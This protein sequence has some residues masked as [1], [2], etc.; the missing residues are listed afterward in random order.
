MH[1]L[2]ERPGSS[3]RSSSRS[4]PGGS[5][6]ASGAASWGDLAACQ[7]YVGQG[8]RPAAEYHERDFDWDEHAAAVRHLVDEQARRGAELRAAAAA[9]PAGAGP[10]A[11]N[12]SEGSSGGSGDDGEGGLAGSSTAEGSGVGPSARQERRERRRQR[13][14]QQ[15]LQ[16]AAAASA[17]AAAASTSGQGWASGEV[18]EPEPWEAFYRAHPSARFFKER[19]YLLLEF[20]RLLTCEHVA[21]IGCGCGSAILPVLKANPGARSTCTDISTTCL[22]QLLAAAAAEGIDRSRLSVFPADATDPAAAPSFQGVGADALLIMFTLSAVDPDRQLV[23]LTHA[24]A[25]LRP[26]GR[27][28]IRDH[29]LYDMVQLRR[30][31]EQ[32]LGPNLY[33]QSDGTMAYFFSL[34]ALSQRA[35]AA[36]LRVEECRYVT[37]VNRNRKTGQEL[38][39]VFVHG[40]FVKPG[41]RELA[42]PLLGRLRSQAAARGSALTLR[43]GPA[44]TRSNADPPAAFTKWLRDNGRSYAAGS[45]LGQ[46]VFARFLGLIEAG[47]RHNSDPDSLYAMGITSEL[48]RGLTGGPGAPTHRRRLLQASADSAPPPA[49]PGADGLGPANGT[50]SSA[51]GA[52]GQMPKTPRFLTSGAVAASDPRVCT[53]P[54]LDNR[55]TLPPAEQQGSCGSCWAFAIAAAMQAQGFQAETQRAVPRLSKQQ[56]VDCSTF[57]PTYGPD[58]TNQGC[59]YGFVPVA[60]EYI[61]QE[62]LL[63][64]QD[65]PYEDAGFDHNNPR[66]PVRRTC[67]AGLRAG[68]PRYFIRSYQQLLPT[69]ERLMMNELCLR[70]ARALIVLVDL[71]DDFMAYRGGVFDKD[72]AWRG[73]N[74]HILTIVGYGTAV[75]R[76]QEVP[77]WLV[78]NSWGDTWGDPSNPGYVRIKRNAGKPGVGLMG[79]ASWVYRITRVFDK[80]PETNTT[81]GGQPPPSTPPPPDCTT[82]GWMAAA[83]HAQKDTEWGYYWAV[84]ATDNCWEY[85]W[86]SND[87]SLDESEDRALQNC[88]E[89][90]GD[91]CEVRR[92]GVNMCQDAVRISELEA[93]ARD[94]AGPGQYF[95][96]ATDSTCERVF[97]WWGEPLRPPLQEAAGRRGPQVHGR[98]CLGRD[99]AKDALYE[100]EWGYAWAVFAE[101]T[102]GSQWAAVNKY[103]LDDA[104]NSTHLG[105]CN[106]NAAQQGLGAWDCRVVA[107]GVAQCEDES[108]WAAAAEAARQ[109]TRFSWQWAVWADKTC[110]HVGSV[111][112][113]E[114][115]DNFLLFFNDPLAECNALSQ[116][117]GMSARSCGFVTRG[118]GAS[119]GWN[120]PDAPPRIY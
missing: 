62:G 25:A 73:D 107:S 43:P 35:E 96:V 67:R 93:W 89:K 46:T 99:L 11:A 76:G 70:G 59:R 24:C 60:I 87:R 106:A 22:D 63:S 90:F 8:A 29:G 77:Y 50:G 2:R 9:A 47:I 66:A 23:M 110:Q 4:S 5:P 21:E 82:R 72:C 30:P 112:N 26:G 10:A 103:T 85:E 15:R 101:S 56:L 53:L 57:G 27:L 58:F 41:E 84:A 55:N 117:D 1:D 49:S 114:D 20:P 36:G 3:G 119:S 65:Y 13:R 44:L 38:R 104:L 34:E 31:P 81:A 12:G 108:R 78:R 7:G 39:R 14:E 98:N 51:W 86:S 111:T 100:T 102:C 105:F 19:R 115:M 69:D 97:G 17:A 94:R 48:D 113:V 68:S 95:G 92:S 118:E 116:A 80:E 120:L 71:C 54:S 28:M 61:M 83:A 45:E 33:R 109:N 52:P 75:E 37:V 88:N 64:E 16:S 40:V 79:L 18:A 42:E 6:R 91:P 32:W 74:G